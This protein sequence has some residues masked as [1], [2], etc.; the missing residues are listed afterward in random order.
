MAFKDENGR[1]TID[2]IAA[3]KDVNNL[4]LANSHLDTINSYLNEMLAESENFSGEGANSIIE[5][6]AEF[7]TKIQDAIEGNKDTADFIDSIVAKYQSI[8][9][10]LKETIDNSINNV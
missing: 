3:K 6:I 7:K 2:E 8:D 4:T 5:M 9:A 10:S 1:I